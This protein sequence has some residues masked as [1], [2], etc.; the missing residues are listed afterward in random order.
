MDSYVSLKLY[1]IEMH[2]RRFLQTECSAWRWDYKEPVPIQV[3]NNRIQ[4][5]ELVFYNTLY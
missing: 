2:F 4:L 3:L 1:L 5:S